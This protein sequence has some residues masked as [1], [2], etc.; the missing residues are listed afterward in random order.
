MMFSTCNLTFDSSIR[1]D[2]ILK[3][4]PIVVIN[5]DVKEASEYLNKTQDFPTPE[6]PII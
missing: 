5:D 2:F 6:S 1:I 3:S 4:M